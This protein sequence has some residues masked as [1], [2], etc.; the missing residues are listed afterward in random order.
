MRKILILLV[1]VAVGCNTVQMEERYYIERIY[2]E[3]D[4]IKHVKRLT[5][6]YE[7]GRVLEI[8]TK[9]NIYY[10]NIDRLEITNE[11]DNNILRFNTWDELYQWVGETTAR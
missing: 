11:T 8:Y 4:G 10:I 1:L 3:K 2:T 9:E 5:N 7:A 6:F